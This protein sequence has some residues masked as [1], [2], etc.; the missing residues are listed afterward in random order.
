MINK[1]I[2][3]NYTRN[4]VKYFSGEHKMAESKRLYDRI[5]TGTKADYSIV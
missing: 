4:V 2:D 3:I 5:C 1:P